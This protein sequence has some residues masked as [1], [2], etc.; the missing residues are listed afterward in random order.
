MYKIYFTNEYG[1]ARSYNEDS[2]SEALKTVEGLRRN[3]RNSFV[4]MASKDP[5]CVSKEGVDHVVNGKLPDGND[6]QWMK[7]RK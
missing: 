1:E 2:L 5:N 6:Y 7:R 4:V 3:T